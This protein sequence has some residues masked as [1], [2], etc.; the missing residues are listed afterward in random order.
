MHGKG[1]VC[2]AGR[3]QHTCGGETGI[4]DK[5]RVVFALP[6]NRIRGIGD[7]RI[8]GLIVPVVGID[9]GISVS[10]IKWL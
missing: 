4:V 1:K 6:M 3:G 2:L 5:Q 10:D 7:N 8:K 9:Q